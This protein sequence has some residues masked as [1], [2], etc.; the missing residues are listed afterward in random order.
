MRRNRW[1]LGVAS[2][3]AVLLG[4]GCGEN[5]TLFNPSF[6]NYTFGGIVPL[7]PGPNSGFVL[8]RVVNKTAV[9]IRY[10]VTAERQVETIDDQGLTIVTTQNETVRLQTFP[11]GLASES[12]ILFNCPLVRIGLGENIDFPTTEPGLFLNAV[13]GQ[14]EGFGVPGFVNPLSAAAGN[15]TCGDT[16]IFETSPEAGTVG[17]VR[18]ATFV[19]RAA[20]QPTVVSGPDTFNNARTVIEEFSFQE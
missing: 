6:I 18:V 17:N 2:A 10:V 1:Q 15:F 20:E 7:T 11:E 19:L 8:V 4:V 13:P 14:A 3:A 9:N 5:A 12:G 16:L